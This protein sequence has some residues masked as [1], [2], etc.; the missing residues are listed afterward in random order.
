ME[1]TTKTITISE[2]ANTENRYTVKDQDG[3]TYSFFKNKQNGEPTKA[4]AQFVELKIKANDTFNI[5]FKVNGKYKNIAFFSEPTGEQATNVTP[6]VDNRRIAKKQDDKDA[7]IM[8]SVAMKSMQ[9]K[10]K[11][12]NA[13]VEEMNR[14]VEYLKT[15]KG[16]F[17]QLSDVDSLERAN[18]K[19]LYSEEQPPADEVDVTK[20]PF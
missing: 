17:K 11:I 3:F 1:L 15:G 16:V 20:I 8:R 5:N 6:F 19:K 18:E 13:D 12:T 4:F 14:R 10:G 7:T 9:F 2:I